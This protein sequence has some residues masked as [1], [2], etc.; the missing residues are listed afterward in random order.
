MDTNNTKKIEINLELKKITKGETY[1]LNNIFFD[2]GKSD[3]MNSS[4]AE[5]KRLVSLLENNVNIVIKIIGY[6]DQIG[7]EKSN[8]KLSEERA[9]AV[10]DYL[11]S[12]GIN[13]NRLSY[14]GKGELNSNK[15]GKLEENRKVVF[16]IIEDKK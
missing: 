9:K 4:T 11:I 12:A 16:K 10:Y 14:E 8:Q 5:L 7:D 2:F 1:N 6:T 15:S 3:L 13:Q